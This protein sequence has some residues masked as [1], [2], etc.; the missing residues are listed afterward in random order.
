MDKNRTRAQSTDLLVSRRKLLAAGATIPIAALAIK[1]IKPAAAAETTVPANAKQNSFA[2]GDFSVSTLLA[3]TRTA[4][5]PQAIFGMNVT[6]E[7]FAEVSQNNFIPADK[8]QFFFTPTVVNAGGQTILFDTGL[9]PA[10]ITGPLAEAGIKPEDVDIIVLTHMH[11]D[12]I[13]GLMNDDGTPTFANARYVTGQAEYDA[14]A[15][16]DNEN[17]DKKVKPL[18]EKMSFIAHPDTWSTCWSL[19]V[20]NW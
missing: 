16:M 6:P 3:G 4:D 11:G 13:G 8:N 12:H 7:E 2:L 1:G 10:G 14:W 5:N 20:N 18:A 17:F 15:K 9:N 19:Q